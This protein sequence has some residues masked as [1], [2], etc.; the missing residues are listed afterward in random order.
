MRL[1][2]GILLFTLMGCTACKKKQA[3]TVIVNIERTPCFGKCPVYTLSIMSN[4]TVR[5]EGLENVSSKGAHTFK[6]PSYK[7]R[8]I[9]QKLENLPFQDY[10][11]EY[12]ATIRDLP[13]TII[14]YKDKKVTFI[15]SKAPV[16]LVRWVE[17][18]EKDILK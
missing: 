4:K 8:K 11:E 6:L 14:T 13:K 7:Y 9:I 17:F 10:E 16:E 12:G 15:R 1:A 2:V 18:V 5:Y 3:T